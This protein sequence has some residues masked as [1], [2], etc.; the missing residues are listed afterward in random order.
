MTTRHSVGWSDEHSGSFGVDTSRGPE[1]TLL[2]GRFG[3]SKDPPTA[4]GVRPQQAETGQ[5]GDGHWHGDDDLSPLRR[6]GY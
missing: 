5:E 2:I 4:E 1:T 6:I 3:P